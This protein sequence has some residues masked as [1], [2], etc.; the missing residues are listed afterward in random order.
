MKFKF[1][2]QCKPKLTVSGCLRD[3]DN[4]DIMNF[5]KKNQAKYV[6]SFPII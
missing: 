1:D 4:E 3:S 2:F 6:I 5:I